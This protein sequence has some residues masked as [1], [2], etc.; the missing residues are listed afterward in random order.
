M[1][2]VVTQTCIGNKHTDCVDVCPVDAFREGPEMLYIDP[3]VCIDCNACITACPERAIYSKSSVPIIMQDFIALNAEKSQIYPV[4]TE[5]IGHDVAASPMASF[6][7]HFAVIG[8]GPSGFYT[9][10]EILKQMPLAKVD[11]FERLPTP[12]GLVRYGVAPD[13]PRIKSVSSSF[14]R[15]AENERFR[16]FG[17]VELGRDIQRTDLLEQYDGV[18]Y[19]TGGSKSRALSIPGAELPNIFGSS[20]FVGWYNGHPDQT[21]LS[22]DLSSQ[23]AV[24]IG[25]GNVALDIARMLVLSPEQLKKTDV[26]DEALNAFKESSVKEVILIARRGIAQAAFTPKELEQ[27]MGLDN[28]DLIIDP[29]DLTLDLQTMEQTELPEF[30]EVKQ[31]INLLKQISQRQHG[32]N[33]RQNKKRIRF[34]FCYSPDC[35]DNDAYGC[36]TLHL[37]RNEIIRDEDGHISIK[38]TREKSL[39]NANLIIHAIGYQGDA[40]E[41]VAFDEQRGV[42]LNQQGR[43][44][45]VNQ[46]SKDKSEGNALNKEYTA[47]WIKRGASGVIGSNKHCAQDTV[48][49]LITDF[50]DANISSAKVVRQDTEDLLVE[51]NVEYIS[52]SDWQLL[53]QYEQDQGQLVGRPRRK[54]TNIKRMLDIIRDARSE[55][56]AKEQQRTN[57]PVKT[58][59]RNCTLCEAMCGIQIKYQGD[60][61]LSIAGDE[62][63]PHS[64][65]HICPKGYSLQDLHNDPDR[66]KTPMQKVNGQWLPISWDDALDRVSTEIVNIQRKY[67]DDAISS[68]T[69][70]PASHSFGILMAIG[71]FRKAL[72]SKNMH[73]G[74]SLDQMP[75]QLMSYL[76]FGHGQLFTIPDIDRTDYMLMLG[77]N[78]AASNGSLMTAGDVLKRLESIEKRGG[79]FILVDPRK[80]ESARYASEHLFIKPGTDALFI[81]GLIQY[82]IQQKLYEPAHL[83]SMLDGFDQLLGMFSQFTLTEI[84]DVCGISEDN[85][86]RIATDFAA[87]EGAI[88]YGRMGL[89][90]QNFSALNHWLVNILNIITGNLDRKGGMMFTKPAVDTG[91]QASTAGSFA[92]F[93]SRVRGLPEFSRELPTSILAEE[94]LTPGEGQ[95]K[96]FICTAGNPVLSVPNGRQLDEALNN[97]DFM[98]SVDFYLNETSRHADIILPP[99][100]PLEHEHY[101]LVFNLLA[102]RNV[103]KYSD[104]LFEHSDETRSD[105]DIMVGITQRINALK[106]GIVDTRKK[107]KMTTEQI[108]DYALRN[109]PYGKSF[110]SHESGKEVSHDYGLSID[111]LKQYPHGLDLGPLQPCLPDHL[112]TQDKL[113]HLLPEPILADFQQM[114]AHFSA[115]KNNS[116]MMISR[117][118]LRTNNSWLHNSQRLIKGKDR[119]ALFIHPADAKEK[120][121]LDKSKALLK[122]R[123]GELTV[124]VVITEDVMQGVVCLPHGWGHDREG[125]ALRVAQ[126]NPGV[127][128]NDLTDDQ[129]V[130]SMSGNAIFNGVPVEIAPC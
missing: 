109:G 86:K 78:P 3:N 40:I 81:Y 122:S 14:D 18:V 51:R 21:K 107:P 64:G 114:K 104:A 20:T 79:K 60:K 118:D 105:F 68:Y 45:T 93:H 56:L 92:K 35:I 108:L 11:M 84:S 85:I 9:A 25:M 24:V 100:G 91:V 94:M 80:T 87:A 124:D 88:C 39:I 59:L 12:F 32:H 31:N 70:N 46:R 26:A 127:S 65:G 112:F 119:C 16:F 102:V 7:G 43:V 117:R 130:D 15:I 72:G 106:L 95:V 126:T 110:T 116:L 44:D 17:N 57:L 5:S 27:L 77:A 30:S 83:T 67:G 71:K 62:E 96:G 19:A 48:N 98:V 101:D 76:M 74:G 97:L 75:H 90:T 52:F 111:V 54:V 82:I 50:V 115:K 47:G 49:Q 34:M 129:R 120:G 128:I 13:H 23:T 29:N 38:A 37:T 42:I 22:V 121:I 58:H 125:I 63:D 36:K 6:S 41:N 103:A 113:I 4:I 99:T 66:L 69:G 28:V 53:D 61:I 1:A 55:K 8:S 123:V 73:S 2:Y 10:E 89:S 33:V